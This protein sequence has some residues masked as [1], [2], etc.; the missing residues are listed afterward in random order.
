MR[1]ITRRYER[2][3]MIVGLVIAVLATSTF[4]PET[5][6]AGQRADKDLPVVDGETQPFPGYP[7]Q[8]DGVGFIDRIGDVEIVIDDGLQKLPSSADL[9]TPRSSH[10]G[11]GR[12]KV[13]D[14]VGF[15]LNEEGAIES[16]WLLKKG[17]R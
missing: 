16:L 10:A 4:L 8:F 11:K 17:K 13:G 15:Q 6:L 5:T 7:R 9:H 2:I 12:F 3:G 14:Y 1:K